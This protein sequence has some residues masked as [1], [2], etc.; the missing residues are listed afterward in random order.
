MPYVA[1]LHA[2]VDREGGGKSQDATMLE[3]FLHSQILG[4]VDCDLQLFKF[5]WRLHFAQAHDML[6]DICRLLILHLRLHRS[7]E[8]FAHGQYHNTRSVTILNHINDR[9][10]LHAKKYQHTCILLQQ[11]AMK[12]LTVSWDHQLKPLQDEDI[13]AL[14]EGDGGSSTEG[15][16]VLSCIWRVPGTI[17]SNETTQ[18]GVLHV[19][20]VHMSCQLNVSCSASDR[21]V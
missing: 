11:L 5:E 13:Q 4:E 21:M 16:R 2:K 18:E 3:L 12:L 17:N 15:Q 7:K 20:L 19:I 14:E 1:S 6:S 10:Q 9:I 8:R